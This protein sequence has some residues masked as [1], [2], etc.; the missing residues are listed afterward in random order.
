M[1]GVAGAG[2]ALASHSQITYFEASDDLLE[3]STRPHVI[4]TLQ[5]LGVHALRV[6]LYWYDVA[7]DPT[8]VNRPNFEATNPASYNWGDYDGGTRGSQAA[9]LASPAD[10]DLARTAVGDHQPRCTVRDAP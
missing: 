6:E 7:P 3:P 4:A 8:S 9:R 10:G 5:H 1:A 2:P